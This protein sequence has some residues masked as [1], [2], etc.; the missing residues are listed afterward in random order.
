MTLKVVALNDLDLVDKAVPPEDS[1]VVRWLKPEDMLANERLNSTTTWR[2]AKRRPSM[3]ASK[4]QK[5][6]MAMYRGAQ[7]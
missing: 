5:R 6:R 1:R 4:K 3:T 2:S 7:V